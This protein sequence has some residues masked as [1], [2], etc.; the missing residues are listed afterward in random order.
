MK[1]E[2]AGLRMIEVNNV[3]ELA[4]FAG[5]DGRTRTRAQPSRAKIES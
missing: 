1:V 5:A 2:N 4:A 3:G